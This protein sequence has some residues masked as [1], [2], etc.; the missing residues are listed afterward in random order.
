M[1]QAKRVVREEHV[2][3]GR[4]M[5]T[6]LVTGW[7]GAKFKDVDLEPWIL[8]WHDTRASGVAMH[9]YIKRDGGEAEEVGREPHETQ[10]T[11]CFL[12]P[13]WREEYLKLQKAI[14]DG[15]IGTLIHPLLGPMT[16]ACAGPQGA[17]MVF[18]SEL[19]SYTVPLR[20]IESAVDTKVDTKN[21]QG[22]EAA[23][24][25][26]DGASDS[27]SV[28]AMPWLGVPGAPTALAIMAFQSA[29]VG[30]YAPA[31]LGAASS[32]VPDASLSSL[33]DNVRL[34][35]QVARDTVL[36]DVSLS[37]FSTDVAK[38]DVLAAIQVLYASC[39]ALDD[40]VRSQ[41]PRLIDYVLPGQLHIAKLALLFYG[42]DGASRI[43]EILVN[44]AGV[45]PE[46]GMIPANARLKMAAPTVS[47]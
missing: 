42:P 37:G 33:L 24:S 27:L 22:P 10:M 2:N 44:N 26:V 21:L 29:A 45:L 31:A 34:A 9:N 15:P 40:A 32:L 38:Y 1:H 11:L 30:F 47:L 23:S 18:A 43:D 12:G 14:D 19:D 7:Q 46:P 39:V 16:A 8:E 5:K 25:D 35:S 3:E 41:R 4:A 17:S 36:L 28:A 13:K 6:S 20:F